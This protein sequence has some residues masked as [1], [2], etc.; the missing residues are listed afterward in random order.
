MTKKYSTKKALV[1]SLLSLVLCFSMLIGTT[2]AWFTDSVTS[3]NNIIKS[4][5]LDIEMY[6]AEGTEDP[7]NANWTDASTGAIFNYDNWEPGYVEVRHIKIANEGTLALKY[8]V[9]IQ[10]NGEVS[11]LADVIDVYY[12]DPAIQVADRAALA[13]APKLGTLTEVL[14]GLG[15][16]GNG[17]LEA[18]TADTITI[19]LK[20]QESAGN[21]YM[22]KSIGSDFSIQLVATQ[23]VS[24][25]DSFGNDY[26]V[27]ATYPEI[28]SAT[29]E[30]NSGATTIKASNVSVTV[31]EGAETGEYKVVVTN[32]NTST[33]ANGQ[34]TFSADI[35]LLKDGVK[36]ERNGATV[37]L[38]EIEVEA[39]KNIVKIL[40]NGN[41][42][43]DYEYDATTGIVKFETDSFSPF[44]VIYEENKT[45]KVSS[46]EEFLAA[47]ADAQPG[48][49][50]DATGV[51]IDVNA[52]GSDI[53][54]GKKA[55]S[56]PGGITIKGLSVVGSYRGGNYFKFDGGS[57]L[58]TVLEDC[59]FEPN[60]RA[61]GVGFGSYEGGAE[62]IVYNNCT[63]KG[64]IIL[65]FANNPNGVATYN[66]CTFTKAA[67]GNHYVMTYGGTHLFNGCTFDY[68]GVTQS[69]MGTINT[70]SVNATSESDGSNFTVVVL[71]GCTRINCGTRKYGANSTLT[72]K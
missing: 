13:N 40:H 4:G 39:D 28:G 51:S 25:N 54:G 19:A 45:V 48:A 70:A 49:I 21:E 68:T 24:E 64:P 43:T 22:N 66:N 35:S 32:K 44:S 38:V 42:V 9:L 60:G 52:V 58:P 26:D 71:D 6:W 12:V 61:M 50:I 63:F 57:N 72:I 46:A 34:T 53:P 65:E 27:D 23:L 59:T 14:E 2:F 31:P 15:E 16:S 41:E 67:S 33:D 30:E 11:D 17:T 69:N 62:S 7:T 29:I 37:Y 47:I 36:V 18:G 1:A 10:A 55:V 3:A 56:V 8:K 20:M 5:N